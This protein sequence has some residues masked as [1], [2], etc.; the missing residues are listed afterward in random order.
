MPHG[1][2]YRW[3]PRILWLHVLS[4]SLIALSYY[5][6]PLV[7]V[8]FIRR[9]R[10]LPFNWI[11]LMF[12]AFI[13]SCGTTHL[14]EVWTVWQPHYFLSGAIKVITAGLSIATAAS[15]IPLLPKLLSIPNPAQMQGLN[16]KL[17]REITE[18]RRT[19]QELRE[20]EERYRS[21]FDL[22][23]YPVWVYDRTSL[24]L[25]AVN[26]A[27]TRNYGYS[28]SEFLA[29][30]ILDIRP[31]EDVP[32]LLDHLSRFDDNH[33]PGP[34]SWRHRTKDGSVFE[35]E[36]TSHPLLF[37]G[38]NA[39]LV[40]AMDITARRRAERKTIG[41]L[42]S[43]PDAVVVVDQKGKI[44]LVNAQVEKLFG[45]KR[46]EL[47]GREMEILVPERLRNGHPA[48]RSM[49]VRDP[50]VRPMG[51]GLE[52]YA[53]HKDG[54][55]FPVEISLSPLETEE[56]R[57]VSSAIRDITDRKKADD[58]LKELDRQLRRQN[59]ELLAV[60]QELE[61][62]GYSISHD[63]R[64]PLRAIDGFSLAL[65][66]D[67]NDKLDPE[68]QGYLQRIRSATGRMGKL[69]DDLLELARMTRTEMHRE[70][71]DLST[72]AEEIAS[73]LRAADP[74]RQAIF[75][76]A[77]DLMILGD[78]TL[79]RVL[80][81]NLIG[82]AWKFTSKQAIARVEVGVRGQGDSKVFFVRDNGAGFDMKYANKL[83]GVF[84]R[85][86]DVSEY[87]GTGVGLA[88]VQRIVH[89]HGGRVWAESTPGEGAA[90]YFQLD[91]G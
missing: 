35:V 84:Q 61:S 71:V 88:S 66:E 87:P 58:E 27:A 82:N 26:S 10:D 15:L 54:H 24:R 2:C 81:E 75:T 5:F 63:L 85:L 74:G 68:G 46:G 67:C 23:P 86:H 70:R 62:F 20:S 69:I 89:R 76:V 83:F 50:R 13:L 72:L 31:P 18:H 56:G 17:E 6:I 25:L 64:A 45:H 7:L 55:E 48:H 14:M 19:E 29:M 65:Q 32:V 38:R 51:P 80:L 3:D 33:D 42:D 22:N 41:L 49:Y 30:T 78:R 8:Y 77:P 1:Y 37:A 21:L 12:G 91:A 40:I 28:E 79:L 9:R 57:L 16:V 44:V 60:N 47:L 59:A 39:E 34:G 73:Q 53:L 43:A 36:I 52:L 4:D 11:F 90:F